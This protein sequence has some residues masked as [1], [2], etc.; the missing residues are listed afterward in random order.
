MNAN[1]TPTRPILRTVFVA[2]ALVATLATGAAIDG[3]AQHY[4]TNAVVP[5][6]TIVASAH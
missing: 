1:Y 4:A 5:G 2:I 6:T 3:L